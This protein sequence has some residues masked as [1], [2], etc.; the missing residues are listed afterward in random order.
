[1][2]RNDYREVL[3]EA[4]KEGMKDAVAELKETQRKNHWRSIE[5]QDGKE[6]AVRSRAKKR[7][8]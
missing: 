3:K 4:Y 6:Q 2:S 8:D 7:G 5:Q 1:M